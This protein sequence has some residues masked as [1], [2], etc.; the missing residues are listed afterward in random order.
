M[1]KLKKMLLTAAVVMT[2]AIC[3]VPAMT[4]NADGFTTD[5]FVQNGFRK[6]LADVPKT[7]PAPKEEHA[8]HIALKAD[9]KAKILSVKSSN[10]K[11]ASIGKAFYKPFTDIFI[12]PKKPGTTKITIVAKTGGKQITCKG[13]V[14]VVKFE[15]PFTKLKIEG[16]DYL[17]EIKCGSTYYLD[18]DTKKD[19]LKLEYKLRS[20]WKI[21]SVFAMNEKYEDIN[22]KKEFKNGIKLFKKYGYYRVL[23][24]NTKTGVE[25]CIY[26]DMPN[27]EEG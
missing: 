13:T 16:K 12:T 25:Q 17:K 5:D 14:T 27:N 22:Y 19:G 11:V 15:K 1:K 10:S 6:T 4:T 24:R 3:L 8:W 7:C 18:V 20:G 26:I 23:L 2:F 21:K 9:N